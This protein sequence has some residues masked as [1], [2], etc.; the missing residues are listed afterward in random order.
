MS[1]TGRL[2]DTAE[3]WFKAAIADPDGDVVLTS[4]YLSINVCDQIATAAQSS[5]LSWT[6][7]TTLDPS[8]VA[9]GYLS[10]K[11]LR[12][13]LDSG[14]DIQHVERLH[15][16][17]FIVG[18]RA[19]LGSANL[20][21][22]GLGSSS[23][24]N[25]ELGIEL[26]QEQAASARTTI[27]S[28]PARTV[29]RG[30]LDQLLERS[31]ELTGTE[32]T[33]RDRLDA[34]SALQLAEQLLEDARDPERSLWLKLKYGEP[35]LEGW[36]QESRFASPKKSRPGFRP[37]DLVF[38]CS[39]KTR[40][41]YAVVEVVSEPVFRPADYIEETDPAFVERWP[42]VNYTKPR[43]VPAK[44]M[45]LKLDELGVHGRGLQN[46]HVRLQF[47]QF[48]AGVRALARLATA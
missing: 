43:L 31:K 11:G 15:A 40:D 5:A 26:D 33:Q 41:C 7:V 47:D 1:S 24:A 38:I 14:V 37:G 48:T 30:D 19:M 22:A 2:I 21:G 20:T 16:K 3:E 23:K 44:L 12:R 29:D 18:H 39:K 17:C 25:R 32:R 36:R 27:A 46:G 8:S 42:W 13:M 45:E 34:V 28:W 6:L 9:N 4:P 10:V 35:S